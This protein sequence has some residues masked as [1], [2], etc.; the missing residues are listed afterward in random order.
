MRTGRSLGRVP[1]CHGGKFTHVNKS[2]EFAAEINARESAIAKE[3]DDRFYADLLKFL[4]G[5]PNG[6]TPDTMGECWAHA[7]RKLIAEDA[8]LATPERRA[9]L[10]KKARGWS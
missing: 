6:I 7:A 9:E 2:E 3:S 1:V 10:L 5:E 8:G 4:A